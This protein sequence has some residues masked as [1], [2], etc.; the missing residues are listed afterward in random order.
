MVHT[1]L[2]NVL[3]LFLI[4]GQLLE[5]ASFNPFDFFLH[6]CGYCHG[7]NNVINHDYIAL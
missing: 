2:R 7:M 4:S 6:E 5:I 3:S 1:L